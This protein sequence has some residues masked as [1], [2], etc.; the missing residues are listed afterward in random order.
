MARLLVVD[1]EL[2]FR[3]YLGRILEAEGHE[4]QTAAD[5]A[6][7]FEAVEDFAPDLLIADWMLRSR[8][9]GLGLAAALRRRFP[10]LAVVVITG[11]PIGDLQR[12]LAG[13]EIE[14]VLEKPFGAAALR[15]VVARV[16]EPRSR[17]G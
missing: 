7:A 5:Y 6:G 17:T 3:S 10:R 13:G 2:H 9:D 16:L 14:A 8:L 11:H 1:D 15:E 12:R 4:V